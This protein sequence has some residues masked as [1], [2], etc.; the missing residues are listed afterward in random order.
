[1]IWD[2]ETIEAI[3]GTGIDKGKEGKLE[4]LKLY[5]HKTQVETI[6]PVKGLF[7]AIGGYILQYTR[8]FYTYHYYTHAL[9]TCIHILMIIY[10]MCIYIIY[11]LLC[12][13]TDRGLI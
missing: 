4:G 9:L 7:F 10:I 3:G 8:T 11:F 1:M 2:T 12:I 6:L 13:S 5:N